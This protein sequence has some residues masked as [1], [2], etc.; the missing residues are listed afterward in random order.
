MPTASIKNAGAVRDANNEAK[1]N[2]SL[3]FKRAESM[4]LQAFKNWSNTTFTFDLRRRGLVR[5]ISAEH[6]NLVYCI[7]VFFGE[8]GTPWERVCCRF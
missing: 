5:C 1:R 2:A 4:M 8:C 6:R 3:W 7:F